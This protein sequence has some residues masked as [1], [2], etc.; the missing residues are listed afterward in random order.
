MDGSNDMQQS[1]PTAKSHLMDSTIPIKSSQ[2]AES[3]FQDSGNCEKDQMMEN[4]KSFSPVEQE[5]AITF[6]DNKSL[7]FQGIFDVK[8]EGD[9]IV[10]YKLDES[11]VIFASMMF[12][13]P[14]IVSWYPRGSKV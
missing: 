4:P 14:K 13:R 7:Y 1:Q 5:I 2:S 12:F 11:R 6:Q 9:W 8:T 10:I 3:S